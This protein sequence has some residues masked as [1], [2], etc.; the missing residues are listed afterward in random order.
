MTNKNDL[1]MVA[2]F[3]GDPAV[4]AD[5]EFY[6]SSW[7]MQVPVWSKLIYKYTDIIES[8]HYAHYHAAIDDNNPE[9]AFQIIVNILKR[10]KCVK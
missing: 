8:E 5:W 7:D 10:M 9:A 2:E 3:M 6:Q 1:R 4:E